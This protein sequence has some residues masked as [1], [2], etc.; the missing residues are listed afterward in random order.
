MAQE[1]G[2]PWGDDDEDQTPST[3]TGTQQ[4]E[5]MDFPAPDPWRPQQETEGAGGMPAGA[6][7]MADPA[8]AAK[9]EETE[10][11]VA[12]ARE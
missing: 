3:S 9:R 5:G 12:S 1:R 6:G 2:W 10:E 4:S 8:V 11:R 7:P